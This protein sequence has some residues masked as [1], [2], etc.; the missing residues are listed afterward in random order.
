MILRTS[1]ICLALTVAGVHDIEAQES[2][3]LSQFAGTWVGLQ[4][5]TVDNPSAQEPQPVTLTLE[6]V[7]GEL[8]GSMTPFLGSA[9]PLTITGAR[10]VGNQLHATADSRRSRNRWQRNVTISFAFIQE[11]EDLT[12]TANLTMGEVPW[13]ELDYKL[14]RKRSRY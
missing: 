12:G 13:L 1:I 3:P 6:L 10:V 11:A 2:V 5:W 14:S 4:T 8:T 7:D 9:Q